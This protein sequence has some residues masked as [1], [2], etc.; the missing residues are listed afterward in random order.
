[1][2]K[3]TAGLKWGHKYGTFLGRWGSFCANVCCHDG[4]DECAVSLLGEDVWEQAVQLPW[5]GG[6]TVLHQPRDGWIV[7]LKAAMLTRQNFLSQGMLFLPSVQTDFPL[8]FTHPHRC[9]PYFPLGRLRSALACPLGFMLGLCSCI[10]TSFFFSPR[11][12]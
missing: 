10:I 12:C 9:V 2:Y 7:A 6:A 4:W 1:M 8:H 3:S 11:P 5:V